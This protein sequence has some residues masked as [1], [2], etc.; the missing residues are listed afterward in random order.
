VVASLQRSEHIPL[1]L[2]TASMKPWNQ[3]LTLMYGDHS[4]KTT[5]DWVRVALIAGEFRMWHWPRRPTPSLHQTVGDGTRS[6]RSQ[7]RTV[8]GAGRKSVQA[9]KRSVRCQRRLALEGLSQLS[10][11]FSPQWIT[12]SFLSQG[13]HGLSA[14]L[15]SPHSPGFIH[16][17]L[18]IRSKKPV[19]LPHLT[20]RPWPSLVCH[21]CSMA[22]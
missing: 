5:G 3:N 21:S 19:R 18:P 14:F 1:A 22:A 17:G 2:S 15:P 11:K 7:R 4:G 12:G 8:A 20:I 16:R 10:A 13:V 6:C 9:E